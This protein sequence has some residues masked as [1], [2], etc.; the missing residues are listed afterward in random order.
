MKKEMAARI[1]RLRN[2]DRTITGIVRRSKVDR[3]ILDFQFTN[4]QGIVQTGIL[5]IHSDLLSEIV[6]TGRRVWYQGIIH[7]EVMITFSENAQ[8]PIEVAVRFVRGL[9]DLYSEA[10]TTPIAKPVLDMEA[11]QL[12]ETI[13]P[14]C[15]Y[16]GCGGADSWPRAK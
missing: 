12:A 16:A 11:K 10:T 7:D 4:M 5:P 9:L 2:P 13:A 15:S 8:L 1:E 3:A 6:D 14:R